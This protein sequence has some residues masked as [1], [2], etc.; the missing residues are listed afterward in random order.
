MS[1][2]QIQSLDRGL[3]ILDLLAVR[4]PELG[5]TEL[6]QR[7]GVHKSTASRLLATLREHD[8]VDQN[9]QTEKFRLAHGL[10]RLARAVAG[11][12]DLVRLA[13]PLLQELAEVT[14]ETVNLAVPDG[15]TIVHIDQI[16]PPQQVVNVNWVG[17]HV[18]LHC[19]SNGKV[20]LASMS[21]KDRARIL[22]R[23]LQRYTPRTIVDSK[24]LAR[25][26]ERVREEG[27]A[28]TLGELE[29]GLNAVAAPVRHPD[30][31]AVA[32]VSVSGPSYRVTP[33]CLPELGERTRDVADAIS[34]R[35]GGQGGAP[36]LAPRATAPSKWGRTASYSGREDR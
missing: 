17:K 1:N 18:P 10:V 36:P 6:A 24:L 20:L 5:V 22:R 28:F 26:L 3:R 2:G 4:G 27:Y 25:Q 29:V 32:V 9:P 15:D 33:Q 12:M 34:Q 35:I 21:A 23:A 16:T 30:G 14:R 13:R 8:L 7:L 31:R 11:E 19:T